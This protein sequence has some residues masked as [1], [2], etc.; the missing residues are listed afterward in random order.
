MAW[1]ASASELQGRTRSRLRISVLTADTAP[2]TS[3][4]L[5]PGRSPA[6]RSTASREPVEAPDGTSRA[7]R[8]A[9]GRPH[10]DRGRRP[11]A[12]IEDFQ[13]RQVCY[14]KGCHRLLPSRPAWVAV[15]AL[16]ACA[17]PDRLAIRHRD[18]RSPGAR[19]GRVRGEGGG[20][21]RGPPACGRPPSAV[22]GIAR[23]CPVILWPERNRRLTACLPRLPGGALDP[24]RPSAG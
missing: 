16:P 2:R 22:A 13:R 14:R 18:S 23:R 8:R 3:L 6:R 17:D 1:S 21:L 15:L 11:P 24:E 12:R 4:A 20:G 10:G 19:L 5:I 9:V 7:G